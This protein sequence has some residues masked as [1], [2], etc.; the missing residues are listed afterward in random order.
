MTV[1]SETN[2]DETVAVALACEHVLGGR[3]EQV[4]PSVPAATLVC[5]L[6]PPPSPTEKGGEIGAK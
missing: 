4:T 6:M 1:A 2:G 3:E 5:E